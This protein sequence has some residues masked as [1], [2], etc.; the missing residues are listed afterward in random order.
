MKSLK[1]D[2]PK[3]YLHKPWELKNDSILKLDVKYPDPIV[4][5]DEAR[6][7]ALDAFKKI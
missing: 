2:I 4:I 5:H 3:K 7:K 1:K 6:R